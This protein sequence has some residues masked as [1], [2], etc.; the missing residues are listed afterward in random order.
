MSSA[1]VYELCKV[2]KRPSKMR[3][4]FLGKVEIVNVICDC[5]KKE[6]RDDTRNGYKTNCR[7]VRRDYY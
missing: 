1:Q 7:R 3:I 5:R 6:R 4:D 2:C